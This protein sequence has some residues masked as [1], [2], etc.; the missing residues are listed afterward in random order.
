V[1]ANFRTNDPALVE[2]ER[3]IKEKEL[4]QAAGLLNELRSKSPNDPRIYAVGAALALAANNPQA[5]LTSADAALARAVGWPRA[6]YLRAVAL[7]QLGRLKDCL[8]ACQAV[9]M[10]DPRHFPAVDLAVSVGRRIENIEIPESILRHV[11]KNDPQE[12]RIWLAL[13]RYLSR[14]KQEEA[15][16]WLTRVIEKDGNNTDALVTL[17]TIE[18]GANQ[19]ESAKQHITKAYENAP[20]DESIR[21]QY[22]RITGNEVPQVPAQAVSA[23]FDE[24]AD[25][26]DS[27]LVSGLG[28]RLPS[29]VAQR[30]R[31]LVPS[32]KL[33]LL[34]LGCGTGLLGAALGRIDGFFVGVDLSEKMLQQAAKHQ[35]YSRLHVAEI[36]EALSATASDEY[37]VIVANDVLVYLADLNAFARETHRVLRAT[38]TAIFSCELAEENEP[39]VVLRSTQRYA[40]RTSYVEKVCR[41][42]CFASYELEPMVVRMDHGKPV[43]SFLVTAKK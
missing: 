39:D 23:L 21:Y 20:A 6:Q 5:A 12:P 33:D 1:F 40:H 43:Q 38:G 25:R 15:A 16:Q 31:A 19:I 27:A 28:Y 8:S 41:D 11:Q 4:P 29:I 36:V 42:A 13:G 26:F 10:A 24:Y 22:A 9:V 37:D 30:V 3:L 35:I 7:E 32:L 34:D 17:A 2:A 18:F 14:H